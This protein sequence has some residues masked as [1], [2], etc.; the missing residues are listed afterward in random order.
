M[1]ILSIIWAECPY[2]TPFSVLV[3]YAVIWSMNAIYEILDKIYWATSRGSLLKK[4]SLAGRDRLDVI[5]PEYNLAVS[6]EEKARDLSSKASKRRIYRELRWTLDS[7]TTDSELEPFV[8]GLPTLLSVSAEQ[9]GSQDVSDAMIA[10]L[11]FHGFAYR[12][13]KLLH[14]CIPPTMLSDNPRFKRAT[15]CLQAINAICNAKKLEMN[16]S[17]QLVRRLEDG[18]FSA[19]LLVLED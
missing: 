19:A 2:Q 14:T 18:Q 15:I 12:I 8:T 5:T 9:S 6:R 4:W 1:T 16:E 17:V 11:D 13:A 10:I 3:R 7:L